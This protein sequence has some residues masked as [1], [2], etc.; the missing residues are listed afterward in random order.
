MIGMTSIMNKRRRELALK[1]DFRKFQDVWRGAGFWKAV[2][3][4]IV[5]LSW[6]Y[7][8]SLRRKA[9]L[10]RKMEEEDVAW[11]MRFGVETSGDASLEAAGVS[12]YN[13][14]RG[15]GTYRPINESFFASGISKIG[16]DWSKFSFVDYGS[17]KGKALMLAAEFPFQEIVGIEYAPGLHEVA[18]RNLSRYKSPSQ[19]CNK[20]RAKMGD[21]LNF[22]QPKTPLLCF[23]FNPFDEATF[24]KVVEN[25]KRDW[26]S[27]PRPI[28]LYYFNWRTVQERIA[29][30]ESEPALK[31]RFVNRNHAVF[32]FR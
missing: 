10:V 14:I 29:I 8:P 7:S 6:R 31:P 26:Q 15:N 11:D 32:E 12:G 21:A 1:N 25:I 27:N 20:L 19:K 22:I 2:R 4:I 28:I 3:Q 18:T 17:G 13:A 9:A 16:E 30:F 24:T 23:F 5:A